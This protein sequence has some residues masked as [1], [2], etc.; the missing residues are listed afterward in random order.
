MAAS[1]DLAPTAVTALLPEGLDLSPAR[2]RLYETALQLFGD[3]GYHAVSIRDIGEALGQQPSAIYFHVESKLELLYELAVIGHTSHQA[4][5]RAAVL[6]AGR[7]PRHQLV[8]I[9]RAHVSTHLDFPAMARLTNREMRALPPAQL[10]QVLGIRTHSEQLFI[11][12]VERGV[13][14]GEFDAPDPFL[15][16]KAIGAMGVRLPEWWTPAS[17]RSAD[18]IRDR[19]MD[20]ALRI[21]GAA[22]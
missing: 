13:Q 16:A 6:D 7:D 5:L 15:A 19:Y 22:T 8:A 14:L 9:V 3:L 2:R 17:P 11:D 21:V 12:I 20:F 18:E 10:D 4:S 1:P